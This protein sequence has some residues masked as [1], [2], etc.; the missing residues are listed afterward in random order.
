MILFVIA[1]V[2]FFILVIFQPPKQDTYSLFAPEMNEIHQHAT[3]LVKI[4]GDKFDFNIPK[5]QNAS[6]WI[7]F[8][9]PYNDIIHIHG[10]KT[11]MGFLFETMNFKVNESCFIFPEGRYFCTNE[12][13]SLKYYINGDKVSSINDYRVLDADRILISY[14][15]ETRQEIELQFDELNSQSTLI[16]DKKHFLE[17]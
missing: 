13:Y 5:Y 3:I 10:D 11:T 1:L 16:E 14:G 12:E 2:A 7:N 9:S 15:P 8:E 6:Y 17:K 4:F